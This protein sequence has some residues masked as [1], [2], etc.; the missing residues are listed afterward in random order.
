MA[1]SR[2]LLGGT[3]DR[4]HVGHHALLHAAAAACD[5]LEIHLVS[6]AMAG[7]KSELIEAFSIRETAIMRWL[8]SEDFAHKAS[9]HPL[10]HEL[11]PAPVR[12]DCDIIACTPDTRSGCE[13]INEIRVANGLAPL[14]I[15][16]VEQVSGPDGE[17]VSSTRVRDGVIDRDG[18]PWFDR[19]AFD[20]VVR[21]PDRLDADLKQPM[22][23][24]HEGP[25]EQPDIAIASAIEAVSGVGLGLDAVIA[26][27]DV[28][29]AALL[30]AGVVPWVGLVDGMTK[31]RPWSGVSTID[32]NRFARRLSCQ[33]PA[34]VLTPALADACIDAL[35]EPTECLIEVQGEEDLAPILLILLAP[36]GAHL[37]Y[38]QPDSGVVVRT[39]NPAAKRRA[40]DLLDSFD[41]A[42]AD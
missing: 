29:V 20:R 19:A 27:G 7:R 4:L 28:T 9:I 5:H 1:L 36:L 24:L 8:T 11:G 6:D 21:M 3:F 12:V 41:E 26:V 34:G 33:N 31:R 23:L 13:E 10:E 40:R 39:V 35:G 17:V 42:E 16:V 38:G 30:S 2:C 37:M 22:G 15:L 32:P 25:E 18:V 14:S